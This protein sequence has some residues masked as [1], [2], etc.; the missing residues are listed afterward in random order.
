M[1][2]FAHI[3]DLMFLDDKNFRYEPY[4]EVCIVQFV[5]MDRTGLD[6]LNLTIDLHFNNLLSVFY[7]LF[8]FLLCCGLTV[9]V[10][11]VVKSKW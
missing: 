4:Y 3:C 9:T 8:H 10:R 1:A 6:I 7:C 11:T 2:V 5:I